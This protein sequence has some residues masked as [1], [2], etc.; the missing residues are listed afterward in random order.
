[1]PEQQTGYSTLII[2]SSRYQSVS[3]SI[4]LTFVKAG[5]SPSLLIRDLTKK[6]AAIFLDPVHAMPGGIDLITLAH[7]FRP[8]TPVYVLY[9]KELPFSHEQLRRMAVHEAIPLPLSSST[10][11]ERLAPEIFEYTFVPVPAEPSFPSPHP[12][13]Q[14]YLPV[15]ATDFLA[16]TCSFFDVFVR[17]PSTGYLKVLSANDTLA[18]HRVL[19]YLEKGVSHFFIGRR[20]HEQCLTYCDALAKNLLDAPGISFEM[21]ISDLFSKGQTVVETIRKEGLNPIHIDYILAYLAHVRALMRQTKLDSHSQIQAFLSNL[22][23]YDHGVGT[24]MVA[25]LLALPLKI[26]T[27]AAFRMV[28]VAALLHDIGIHEL[29][30]GLQAKLEADENSLT[31]DERELYEMHPA[32]G[33]ELL[34]RIPGIDEVTVQAVAQHHERRNN[35]GFPGKVTA[36]NINRI[37]ELIGISDEFIKLV[38]KSKENPALDC[39]REMQTKVFDGFSYSVVE[40][41]RTVFMMTKS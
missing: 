27:E 38:V 2:N 25:G 30:K 34:N 31:H 29:P 40:S 8:A 14:E 5:G 11:K 6:F 12:E 26:E 20:G 21:K 10:I 35:K 18:P 33:A 7:R 17:L 36:S 1:L 24:A 37:A 3:S 19:S 39:L 23:A 32:L 9:D 4:P 16:G 13:D 41:F 22:A 28:G 15:P